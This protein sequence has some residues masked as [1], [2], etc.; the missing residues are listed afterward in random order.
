[1][2]IRKLSDTEAGIDTTTVTTQIVT[3][4]SLLYDKNSLERTIED[5][6]ENNTQVNQKIQE[7]ID[8]VDSQIT[9]LRNLGIITKAEYNEQHPVEPVAPIQE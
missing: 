8:A 7:Q 1:M 6:N 3:I 2:N 9:E 5:N 4:D